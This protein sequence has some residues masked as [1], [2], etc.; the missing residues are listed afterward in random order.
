MWLF[1]AVFTVLRV[2]MIDVPIFIFAYIGCLARNTSACYYRTHASE[3]LH[4]GAKWLCPRCQK[5]EELVITQ[6]F[7]VLI[8]YTVILAV[9]GEEREHRYYPVPTKREKQAEL[10]RRIHELEQQL[11]SRKKKK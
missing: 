3:W 8:L 5:E 10:E 2:I 9:I 4:D 6:I 1:Y 7:I 11:S